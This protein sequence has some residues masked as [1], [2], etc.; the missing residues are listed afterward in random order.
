MN[1]MTSSLL[2]SC[3]TQLM[4]EMLTID[5]TFGKFLRIDKNV[6]VGHRSVGSGG[7]PEAGG[8][9]SW[10]GLWITC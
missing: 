8:S 10:P 2:L 5:H 6:G 9:L 3:Q 4:V 7:R 1:S